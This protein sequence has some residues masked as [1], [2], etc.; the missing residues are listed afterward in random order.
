MW[1][2]AAILTAL[3]FAQSGGPDGRRHQVR[4]GHRAGQV[5]GQRHCTC[6]TRS[7]A[8]GQLQN[9]AYGYLWPMGP[10]FCSVTL[11]APAGVGGPAAVVGPA[12]LPG[13]LRRRPA[14]PA[15]CGSGTPWAQVV[16]GF[17]YVLTPRLTTLLGAI[18]VEVWPMALAPW[19][20]LP[21]VTGLA[22]GL[23]PPGGRA[24]RAGRGDLRRRQRRRRVGR[25][26]ARRGLDPDPRRRSPEVAAAGVV[27][28]V[29][30]ARHL[31]VVGSAAAAGPLQPAV[32][33]LHRERHD[34]DAAHR[35]RPDAAR[36]LRLGRLLRGHRLPG[37]AAAGHHAVPR[38]RR[39]R[40]GRT[41]ARRHR[42]PGQPAPAV[43][44]AWAAGRRRP[45]RVRLRRGPGRILRRRPAA[46]P[47][48]G[49]GSLPQPAQV[50]RGAAP[51]ARPRDGTPARV[52][53]DP[54]LG[55]ARASHRAAHPGGQ[56]VGAGRSRAARGSPG[57]DCAA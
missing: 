27:D 46:G 57:R 49:A 13:V 16:A 47:G 48:R 35:P 7:A 8:F 52:P 18:S 54:V 43:P 22:A 14:G 23:D 32:P 53:A 3:A 1:G 50:R 9:Q 40:R 24:Q 33:R 44:D 15:H 31:L 28:A 2:Y 56:R 37:R 5:P 25:A 30:G 10:F 4:P 45:G 36:H 38:R 20:L 55:R 41:R 51:A 39:R 21:L 26:P 17:A 19:V 6:G 29:H 12:A 42:G 34:H 11:A